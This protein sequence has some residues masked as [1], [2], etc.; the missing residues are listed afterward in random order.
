MIYAAILAAGK[1]SRF[2]ST[3]QLAVLDSESLIQRA[4]AVATKVCRERTIVIAGASW[5]EVTRSAASRCPFFAINENYDDGIGSSIAF[6]T[7]RIAS[8]ADA[9]LIL[10]ADQ[11]LITDTHLRCLVDTWSGDENEIVASAFANKAGPPILF[12][13]GA[14]TKLMRLTGDS[15]ARPLLRDDQ[16]NV[17]TVPCDEAAVDIDTRDDLVPYC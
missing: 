9:I 5:K 4:A 16:F 6:V 12:P 17:V 1:S 2:G 14:F 7:R 13:R 8:K 15:G 10:L 3:K 11:I